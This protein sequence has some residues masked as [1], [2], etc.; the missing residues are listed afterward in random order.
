[1][2]IEPMIVNITVTGSTSLSFTLQYGSSE[3]TSLTASSSAS[4]FDSAVTAIIDGASGSDIV[5]TKSVVDNQT[6]FQV[7]FFEVTQRTDTLQVGSYDSS[8]NTIDIDTIQM[9][10]YPTDLVLGLSS[11]QTETIS[12]PDSADS[13]V[14]DQLYDIISV[15]CTKSPAGQVYWSHSYD[16]TTGAI[17]GTLDNSVDP[18]CGR[19][20]LK[21]PYIVFRASA[22][23]DDSTREEVSNIPVVIYQWVRTI[24]IQKSIKL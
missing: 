1:M 6:I 5:V 15:T 7:V 22:S 14:E 13:I 21:N 10:R 8:L 4:Q 20:S 17:W 16:G 12:L 11:R 3:S 9:S 23:E 19:Y 2:Y 24:L 18:Q